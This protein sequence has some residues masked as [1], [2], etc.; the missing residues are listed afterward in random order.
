[1]RW[2]GDLTLTR[3]EMKE[4]LKYLNN[5]K[6][7]LTSDDKYKLD[8]IKKRFENCTKKQEGGIDVLDIVTKGIKVFNGFED[9][10]NQVNFPRLI[11]NVY[12]GLGRLKFMETCS[13]Q[14][15]GKNKTPNVNSRIPSKATKSAKVKKIGKATKPVNKSTKRINQSKSTKNDK[16]K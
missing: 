9:N 16:V 6:D 3:E 11:G 12:D 2:E 14:R 5:N 10:T 13:G 4:L 1:M 8:E 15:G 7:K